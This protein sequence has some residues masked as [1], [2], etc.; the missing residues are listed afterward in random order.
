[1]TYLTEQLMKR[2]T[3]FSKDEKR[4]IAEI[5]WREMEDVPVD[6]DNRIDEDFFIWPK[7]TDRFEV[8]AEIEQLYDVSIG[9]DLMGLVLLQ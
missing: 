9:E 1:M 8:W 3:P 6:D 7:G 4:E 2:L 5:I